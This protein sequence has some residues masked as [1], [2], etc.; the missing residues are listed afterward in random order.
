MSDKHTVIWITVYAHEERLHQ[1]Y[2]LCT[3]TKVS[4]QYISAVWEEGGY[5]TSPTHKAKS[6][7]S[8][9]KSHESRLNKSQIIQV[10]KKQ[11]QRSRGSTREQ[12]KISPKN[13][14]ENGYK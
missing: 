11:A 10:E 2:F 12:K 5:I 9:C 6:K 8:S 3:H 4:Q 14:L 13:K 1:V 7:H